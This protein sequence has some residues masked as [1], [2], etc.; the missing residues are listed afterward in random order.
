M[1]SPPR[2]CPEETAQ[3]GADQYDF[4]RVGFRREAGTEFRLHD[5]QGV[6]ELSCRGRGHEVLTGDHFRDRPS[7]Q[8]LVEADARDLVGVLHRPQLPAGKFKAVDVR[9]TDPGDRCAGP[10][11]GLT[12]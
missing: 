9:D 5:R 8:L 1:T 7:G 6:T 12:V 10:V 4:V 3:L 11:L 2:G